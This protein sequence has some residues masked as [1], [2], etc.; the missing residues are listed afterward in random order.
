MR[1]RTL[2]TLYSK[3]GK[4]SKKSAVSFCPLNRPH[5]PVAC[6]S[7]EG[8]GGR[9]DRLPEVIGFQTILRRPKECSEM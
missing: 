1:L 7:A 4:Y 3:R 5:Y 8:V 6:V 2:L 9:G